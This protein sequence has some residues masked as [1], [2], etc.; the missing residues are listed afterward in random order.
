[1]YRG[2]DI[3]AA[4][5]TLAEQQQVP[6]YLIDLCEPTTTLTVADYQAQAQALI[7]QLQAQ[8]HR[9]LLLV[10]GSGLYL[11][12]IAKGLKIPRVA[13]QPGLRS[14]LA[15]LGQPQCYAFLQ[16]VDPIAAARIHANDSV[17]TLR[18]LEVY[19]VTGDPISNQ[20]GAHPPA[21]PILHLGLDC[22][23]PS[24][25]D[26]RIDQRLQQMI[27]A[28]L[29]QEV[30]QL[31]HRC[32]PDL[33]L[34]KTLGYAEIQQYLQGEITFASARALIAQHTRQFA[35]RQRTWFRKQPQLEWFNACSPTLLKDVWA[36]IQQ[37]QSHL[38]T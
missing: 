1:V 28:G 7:A 24:A 5:P 35:K 3:G 26:Q 13:P 27:D 36:R 34:L 29:V 6:H 21:Y 32:G 25:L 18:A 2:F 16:Q 11:D 17:R 12:A 23:P 19:Y 15:H 10:G 31:I 8:G 14:Q 38:A 37:F 4:K 22:I 30:Q 20:Q 9:S 33:P